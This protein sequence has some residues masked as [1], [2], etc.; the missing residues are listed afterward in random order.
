MAEK[1]DDIA[2]GRVYNTITAKGQRT[3]LSKVK[4]NIAFMAWSAT[5]TNA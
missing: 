3:N 4:F 5:T 2:A 1:G